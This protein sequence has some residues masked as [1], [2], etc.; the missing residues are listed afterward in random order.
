MWHSA[1]EGGEFREVWRDIRETESSKEEEAG[2]VARVNDS[3]FLKIV[4]L[5]RLHNWFSED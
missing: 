1:G 4:T 3:L 5:M 2:W